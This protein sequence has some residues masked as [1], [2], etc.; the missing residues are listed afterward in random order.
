MQIENTSI[1]TF[2]TA[3]ENET[4]IEQLKRLA[5][6]MASDL[7][8]TKETLFKICEMFGLLKDGV[9]AEKPKIKT[10]LDN[11]SDVSL[12]LM[13]NPQKVTAKFAFLAEMITIAKK[14]QSF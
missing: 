2:L 10:I 12:G 3:I 5:I 9:F 1:A 6:I 7:K 13:F 14:Y 8:T 4:D 11:V